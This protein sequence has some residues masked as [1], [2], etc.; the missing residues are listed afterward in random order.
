M[1][2]C[3]C[4][5]LAEAGLPFSRVSRHVVREKSIRY[6]PSST[7]HLRWACRPLL[8]SRAA[9]LTL[10]RPDPCDVHGPTAFKTMARRVLPGMDG[11]PRERAKAVGPDGGL[12]QTVLGA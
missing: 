6:G 1:I 4:K 3:E 8:S 7:L 11:R 5:R 2:P 10:L 12:P 9:L